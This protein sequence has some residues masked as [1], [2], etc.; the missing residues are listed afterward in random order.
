MWPGEI[1]S[2]KGER[3]KQTD[4]QTERKRE[5]GTHRDR[6][7]IVPDWL[8]GEQRDPTKHPDVQFPLPRNVRE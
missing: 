4:K 6:G 2:Q 8:L 1:L 3:E 7:E 5:R